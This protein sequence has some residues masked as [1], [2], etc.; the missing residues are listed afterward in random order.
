VPDDLENAERGAIVSQE[1]GMTNV[2]GMR[3]LEKLGTLFVAPQVLVYEGMIIGESS[4]EKDW[5]VNPC[6]TKKLTNIRTHSAD[7]TIRLNPPR[8]FNIEDAISY[9]R[10]SWHFYN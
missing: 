4:T 8:V 5:N 3:D 1:N 6:K 10:G 2:Y 7:E 9:I